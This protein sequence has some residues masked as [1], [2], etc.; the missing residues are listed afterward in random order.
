M[1]ACARPYGAIDGFGPHSPTLSAASDATSIRIAAPARRPCPERPCRFSHSERTH[2]G[3]QSLSPCKASRK[4][5]P[6][7]R[8]GSPAF[9]RRAAAPDLSGASVPLYGSGDKKDLRHHANDAQQKL[10]KREKRKAL[11][12]FPLL[13]CRPYG[14]RSWGP[15]LRVHQAHLRR[16]RSGRSGRSGRAGRRL[17]H[18]T[19]V[20][21]RWRCGRCGP[22]RR[23]VLIAAQQQH[24]CGG[25]D[26]R[27]KNLVFHRGSLMNLFRFRPARGC[28]AAAIERHET[29]KEAGSVFRPRQIGSDAGH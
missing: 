3:H 20:G 21:A 13:L 9:G 29:K 17:R 8:A 11:W 25:Q 28:T 24:R 2:I 7:H 6:A 12:R 18:D 1:A 26:Q 10:K 27:P 5:R 23:I 15:G 19:T 22:R 4:E 14:G 16:R